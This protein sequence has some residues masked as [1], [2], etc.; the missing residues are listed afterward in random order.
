MLVKSEQFPTPRLS[1]HQPCGSKD[2]RE[3]NGIDIF[4]C[5]SGNSNTFKWA[6]RAFRLTI[7][8]VLLA[9][10]SSTKIPIRAGFYCHLREVYKKLQLPASGWDKLIWSWSELIKT[11]KQTNP[12]LI[13]VCLEYN[14]WSMNFTL[15][16][17][18]FHWNK[19]KTTIMKDINL[20]I[21]AKSKNLGWEKWWPNGS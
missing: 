5:E 10:E 6:N 11:K 14:N 19:D 1:Y 21:A 20:Q 8:K 3:T 13:C 9:S 7:S 2:L 15:Y 16:I 18:C 12:I 4:Q 17:Y